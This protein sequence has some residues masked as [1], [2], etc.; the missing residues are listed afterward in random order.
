M[1]EQLANLQKSSELINRPDLWVVGTEYDFG[2]GLYG[3]RFTTTVTA[4]ANEQVS[5]T[6]MNQNVKILS[7]GGTFNVGAPNSDFPVPYIS[8]SGEWASSVW[9]NSTPICRF[10]S[11]T[12]LARTN[13]PVDVWM[14][15]KK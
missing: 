2:G 12:G 3:Q 10:V 4:N 13:A 1:A 7:Y 11:K 5:V 8:D 15:Y 6:L 9:S 14:L